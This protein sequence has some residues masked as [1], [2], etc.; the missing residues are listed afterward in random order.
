[1]DENSKQITNIKEIAKT[2]VTQHTIDFRR[3]RKKHKQNTSKKS[4]K[5]ARRKRWEKDERRENWTK[6]RKKHNE[7]RKKNITPWG[8]EKTIT[9]PGKWLIDLI[10]CNGKE[11]GKGDTGNKTEQLRLE[12][13]QEKLDSKPQVTKEIVTQPRKQLWCLLSRSQLCIN[14]LAGRTY[15]WLCLFFLRCL[16]FRSNAVCCFVV[17]SVLYFWLSTLM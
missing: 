11:K 9:A 12:I 1:M 7:N 14:T 13:M 8:P 17:V 15:L 6:T 10:P 3:N 16:W 5:Q 4:Q 2:H